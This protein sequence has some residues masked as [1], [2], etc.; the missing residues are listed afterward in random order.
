MFLYRF[1]SLYRY[2]TH[3]YENLYHRIYGFA[4]PEE[5]KL[6]PAPLFIFLPGI[7]D[8]ANTPQF[9]IIL[10]QMVLRGFVAV[11]IAYDTRA[12]TQFA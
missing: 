6:T 11:V 8:D 10:W 12:E 4:P 7:D 1:R 9:E 3:R 5:E 2:E